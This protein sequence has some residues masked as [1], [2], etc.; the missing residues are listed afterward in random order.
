LAAEFVAEAEDIESKELSSRIAATLRIP[1]S[2]QGAP[3]GGPGVP[4]SSGLQAQAVGPSFRH[5]A[6]KRMAPVKGPFFLD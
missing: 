2:A 6:S 3:S 5:L 4:F 1:L